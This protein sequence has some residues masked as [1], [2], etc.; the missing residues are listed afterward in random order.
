MKKNSNCAGFSEASSIPIIFKHVS[1]IILEIY[2]VASI[3]V[4]HVAPSGWTFR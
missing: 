3:I 1:L 2:V 4:S